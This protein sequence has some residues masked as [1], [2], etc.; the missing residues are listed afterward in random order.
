[1]GAVKKT[2][3]RVPPTGIDISA[4][5]RST[6]QAGA[7]KLGGEIEAL[8]GELK[9]NA[10][11]L[12]LLPDVEIYHKA[13][14]WAVR[15]EEFYRSNEVGLAKRL[16]KQG[17]ERAKAL[18][19]GEAPWLSAT[20]LVVRGYV[21][22]IDGSVQ[23]YGVVVPVGV[24]ASWNSF[25]S[26]PAHRLDV[27]LHGRDDTL[28]ELRFLGERERS[29]GDFAPSNTIVLHPYGRYCNA[30]KFAGETD[31]FEEIEHVR[32][33]YS[34][35]PHR[36]A[37]RGFS[38]GGAG[39]WHLAAHHAGFW[40]AAAPGAGFAE[41]AIYTGALAKAPF[42]PDYE[43]RLWH[44]Y[45]ATDYAA[46]LFNCGLIAYSGELDK[47]KQAADMMA[48]AMKA[49]GLEMRH[50][51]GPKVQHKYEPEAKKELARQFDALMEKG[52]ERVPKKVKLTTFT[53]RY[54]QQ[55]WVAVDALEKHWERARVEAEITQENDVQVQT[56]NVSALTLAI[57]PPYF[58]QKKRLN[59]S[60]DGKALDVATADIGHLHCIKDGG[61]WKLG[62]MRG[63]HKKHGLQG[64]MDDA[65]LDSF[66]MVQPTGTPLSTASGKWVK[67]ELARATSAWRGQFRGCPRVKNDLEI[68]EE[69]MRASHVVLWG[70]AQSNRLLGRMAGKLP[71]EWSGSEFRL[72][73]KT[74]SAATHAPVLIFPNPLN[75][76]KYV[77]VNSGFTFSEFGSASNAQQ[78]PKLPDW[79]VVDMA[80]PIAERLRSGIREAGFFNERWE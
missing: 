47:Q 2:E 33:Q 11:L 14:D 50:I 66:I 36:I 4:E 7:A 54:N 41:T 71:V 75:P 80:V 57:F 6:L 79:A 68:T 3:P 65:F 58:Q 63:L 73:G 25:Y 1:M 26:G 70:D 5:D 48:K 16:L 23:P 24:K 17:M 76:E 19:R 67:E 42:P 69:E 37:I 20:G 62:E 61:D 59:V 34:I 78:T 10:K 32:G 56:E 13:V 55:E 38:M 29:L 72:R 31:V 49:E 64:P 46:N 77:V 53:T 15:Y 44:L 9:G 40:T 60:V 18:R 52:K 12:G 51:I 21:S 28:T 39:T 43:Q 45:D 30:F 8:R 27:W 74:Y 22:R 35:D